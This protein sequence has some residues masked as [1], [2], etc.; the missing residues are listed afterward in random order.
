MTKYGT[1]MGLFY[2]LKKVPTNPEKTCCSQFFVMHVRCF[3]A[4]FDKLYKV[5]RLGMVGIFLKKVMENWS[6]VICSCYM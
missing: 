5:V 2:W 6:T 4:Y 1:E 3:I